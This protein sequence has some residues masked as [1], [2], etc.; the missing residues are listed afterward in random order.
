MC[1]YQSDLR[2]ALSSSSPDLISLPC[3]TLGCLL[4]SLLSQGSSSL[5][6]LVLRAP[7]GHDPIPLC[8]SRRCIWEEASFCSSTSTYFSQASIDQRVESRF[9][10]VEVLVFPEHPPHTRN[11][12]SNETARFSLELQLRAPTSVRGLGNQPQYSRER[13]GDSVLNPSMRQR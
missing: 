1:V 7:Q 13:A 6:S 12:L 11:A 8:Y 4:S 10:A 3:F 2:A 5:W 9:G